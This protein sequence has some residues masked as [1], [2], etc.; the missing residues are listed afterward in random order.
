MQ[1]MLWLRSLVKRRTRHGSWAYIL[2]SL[3]YLPPM[4]WTAGGLSFHVRPYQLLPLLIPIVVVLVQLAYPT[5]L[6]WA[7]IVMPSVFC[8][9]VGVFFVVVTAPARI[10]QH[11]LAAL[12]ISSVTAAV[13]VLVCVAL[14][15][16]RPKLAA[17]VSVSVTQDRWET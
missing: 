12:V 7:V 9:G 2:W 11:E 3:A 8:A 16:A 5:L 1:T 4:V 17:A 10:R 14:W 6:G 15:F 13:Y